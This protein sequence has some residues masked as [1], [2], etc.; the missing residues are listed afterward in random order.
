MRNSLN[1]G[2][3]SHLPKKDLTQQQLTGKLALV[4]DSIKE[5]KKALTWLLQEE[6]EL[7]QALKGK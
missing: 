1:T 7:V 4:R 3:I 6:Q 5:H 2:D